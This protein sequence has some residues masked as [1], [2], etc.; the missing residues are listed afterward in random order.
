MK[1]I[2][3]IHQFV[4]EQPDHLA[5]VD[6]TGSLTYAELNAKAEELASDYVAKG[7]VAGQAVG[8]C[9]PYGKDIMVH[10]VALHKI[11]AVFVPIDNSYPEDRVKMIKEDCA[12]AEL[13]TD[14]AI[15]LFTS[16][17]TGRPKGVAHSHKSLMATV[18]WMTHHLGTPMSPQTHTGIISGLSFL[19]THMML[20]PTLA[21]GGTLF[22][23]NP[24]ER[25]DADALYGFLKRNAIT[26]IFMTAALGMVMV[27][28]F[29]T[30]GTT[31]WV[32]GEKLRSFN[33]V[34]GQSLVNIY[35]STEGAPVC[36]AVIRGDEREIT[37]GHPCEG[38]TAR[39]VDENMQDVPRGEVGELIYTSDIMAIGYLHLPEQTAQKWTLIDGVRYYHTGDRV[40][41]D[42]EG[43]MYCLGR[44]DNM[45][46]I[47][48]FRV[49]T[50]EVERRISSVLPGIEVAVVL[51]KV[52]GIEHLV[53]FYQSTETI[54]ALAGMP[55]E[56]VKKEI[57]KYLA[58]YMVPDLW[59]GLEKFPRNAN[60]KV[61]RTELA[62]PSHDN[63]R[64]SVIYNEVEMRV[65]EAAK[66]VLG[67]NISL[68]DNFFEYGGTS[69][70]A[71]KL[72]SML[73]A[74]GIH[75]T[76]SMIMQLKVLRKVAADAKVDYERLWTPEQYNEIKD[77]FAQRGETIQR[78]LPLTTE[79]EDI[80]LRYLMHPDSTAFRNVFMLKMDSHVEES[81]LREAIDR[82]SDEHEVLRSA[83]VIHHRAFFQQVIT[84]RRL[85]LDIIPMPNGTENE[86]EHP[87]LRV[88][89][90][91][92]QLM[93]LPF[94]PEVS[95]IIRFA[96]IPM[97]DGTSFLLCLVHNVSVSMYIARQALFGIMS[98]LS[99]QYPD[100]VSIS[101]W[102]D[103]LE[104]ALGNS[105]A[106]KP[107]APKM[108][109]L[110]VPQQLI[111][112][113]SPLCPDKQAV[114]FVHT[115][116]TG[117]DAYYRL[118]DRIGQDCS[119]AVLEP[120]NLF[121]SDDIQH[122]IKAI[123][124]KYIEILRDYQPEGPYI[125]GGWCYG[126]V[127]AHEMAC[128]LQ[129]QG[130]EVKHLF[131]FDSHALAENRLVSM[132][133]YM[134]GAVDRKYFEESPLFEDLRG[135]GL[136]DA[137]VRNSSQVNYDLMHHVP[138]RFDGPVTYFK[139]MQIPLAA[140]GKAKDYWKEMMKFDAGNYE[141]YCNREKMQIILTPHEHDL[142]MDDETLAITVPVIKEIID[143]N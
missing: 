64:L 87:L 99:T 54:D 53:C 140:T 143:A 60:G 11:G 28:T 29:D 44:T 100:D 128:Q 21:A 25:M 3:K 24:V 124:K 52:H 130:A 107:I 4:S 18:N 132:A 55:V 17:T 103:L 142:M 108:S 10:A 101:G 15:I 92:R 46:K 70:G 39:V 138:S 5:L 74:A 63:E 2:D 117:S 61:V 93:H 120:Y 31:I 94:D 113:Y 84:G 95:S 104:M 68:D 81:I 122:G 129:Q 123:A 48:G 127:V 78:V 116:N 86:G 50:G 32:G 89:E 72:A 109:E 9:V 19:A 111:R 33:P 133:K 77:S 76:G 51:R 83:I 106:D 119:F 125:L 6:E 114:T 115:G 45:V 80:L 102:R 65:V 88:K 41:Q 67:A 58:E 23:A 22:F 59:V 26:H 30:T 1:F 139:P 16:G 112:A 90:V 135:Q 20:F 105:A 8:V 126:G 134:F 110:S 137:M 71:I 91:Y 75:V 36:S 27:E 85:P 14:M 98:R 40:R 62:V 131:L 7:V 97:P 49:E 38:V 43:K 136:L 73:R 96:Y 66:T 82:V 47:R 35:G 42:A 141:N 57:S 13:D 34:A 79:H 69:L 121:H 56:D 37:I 12:S 118:A